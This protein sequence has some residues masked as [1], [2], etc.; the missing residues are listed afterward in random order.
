[1][2]IRTTASHDALDPSAC[3]GAL[4]RS[5]RRTRIGAA[6]RRLA[7]MVAA[8]VVLTP[9]MGTALAH[10]AGPQHELSLAPVAPVLS[11]PI[12]IEGHPPTPALEGVIAALPQMDGLAEEL[13]RAQIEAIA[14]A[15]RRG[16]ERNPDELLSFANMRI[17]RRIVE[18]I[19]RAAEE[20][21]VDPV[22]MMAL[23][24]KESSFSPHVKARTSSAEGLFQFLAKTWLE[25]VRD[26]GPKYGFAEAAAAIE[27]VDGQVAIPDAAM[28]ER[29]LG[30]RRDPYVSA[31][32]AGEMLKR[33]RARIERRL[34]R[35]LTQSEGY[36]I[37]FLGA[38]SAGRLME[39]VSE[40]PK[41]SAPRSFPQAAK[42]NRALFF[43][44][45][46]RKTRH[47]TVAEV[48]QRIDSMIDTRLVRY[49]SVAEVAAGTPPL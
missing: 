25:I 20:T 45:D 10:V 27:T 24:D 34:G 3:I 16:A 21:G 9:L 33:D 2:A 49:V 39:L 35:A 41:E 47:L 40:K 28:R 48:Y 6:I 30:L 8:G 36:I 37:H 29:V 7:A 12:F 31:L 44:R 38:G 14:S 11:P 17:P 19:L 15:A 32:M 1:M 23:A 13:L 22:Y 46:G 42:A 5:H 43:E 4:V 18:T 26:Y